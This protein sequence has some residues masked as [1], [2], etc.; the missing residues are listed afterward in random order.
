M[1]YHI[2]YLPGDGIGPEVGKAA[3]EAL[4]T[5]GQIYGHEFNIQ[6]ALIG[7]IA[8]DET[9]EPLPKPTQVICQRADAVFLGAGKASFFGTK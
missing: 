9:G 6:E 8:I 5:I 2:A 1:T 7:G 3:I 4:K